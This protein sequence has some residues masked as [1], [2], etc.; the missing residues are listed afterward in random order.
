[1]SGKRLGV[2][3]YEWGSEQN[4]DT[5]RTERARRCCG[6]TLRVSG[7]SSSF[8]DEE[9]RRARTGLAKLDAR[10]LCCVERVSHTC[11][12]LL[13]DERAHRRARPFVLVLVPRRKLVQFTNESDSD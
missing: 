8:G 4:V 5:P 7:S 11:T 9:L 3:D 6:M 10:M 1:M 12:H 2:A 13:R